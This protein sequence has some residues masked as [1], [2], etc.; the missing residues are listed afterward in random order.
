MDE[1]K[2]EDQYKNFITH[3]LDRQKDV[4]KKWEEVESLY[5]GDYS[6]LIGGDMVDYYVKTYMLSSAIET[7]VAIT[8]PPPN[9]Q[10]IAEPSNKEQDPD[11]NSAKTAKALA[12]YFMHHNGGYAKIED[13]ATDYFLLNRCVFKVGYRPRGSEKK[14]SGT[15]DKQVFYTEGDNGDGQPYFD[16]VDRKDF[17]IEDGFKTIRDSEVPG[18]RVA[19]RVYPHVSWVKNNKAFKSYAEGKDRR[20]D[21]YKGTMKF[22]H[23]KIDEHD[24][25][26]D[27]SESVSKEL[28]YVRLW[29]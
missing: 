19:Y 1:L 3:G 28:E 26:V 7:Q 23:Q 12:N 11:I 18:G 21:E 13:G 22:P 16:K 15:I 14:N 10:F 17:I 27:D 8:M 9:F 24:P 25:I 5:D 6:P 29:F 20:L 4:R 2:K